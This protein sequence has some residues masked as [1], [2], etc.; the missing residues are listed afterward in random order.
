MKVYQVLV[1]YVASKLNR[2]F[3]YVYN[4]DIPLYSRVIVSFNNRQCVGFIID[5]IETDSLD[6]YQKK[7]GVIIKNIDQV[8]D[9]EPLINEELF[10]LAKKVADYYLCPLISVILAML[11]PSLKPNKSSLHGVKVAFDTYVE[12][13]PGATFDNLTV[14]QAEVFYK[15][16]Q[17]KILKRDLSKTIVEN[18]LKKNKI[19]LVNIE[20]NR[21]KLDS[22]KEY[23][24][25]ELNDEQKIAYEDFISSDDK[26]YLLYGVT[27]SGKTE[28]YL[29]LTRYYLERKQKVLILVPEI[30]LSYLMVE[31][32]TSLFDKVAVLHSS[33]SDGERYDTYRNIKKGEYDVVIGT[34]SA[35]FAPL[36]NL[37]LIIIDEE[38]ADTYKQ[39]DNLPYYNALTVA[40]MRLINGKLLLGSATPSLESKARALKK[41]YHELRLTK[42]VND[43]SLPECEIV[44]MSDYHNIDRNSFLISKRLRELIKD[45][46]EKQEQVILLVNRR[47]FA[48]FVS[49]KSC[50]HI[51][52]CPSCDTALTYHKD[53]NKL[54]CHHCG[55]EEDMILTCPKCHSSKVYKSGFGTE[56]VVDEAKKLFP[57][58]RILRLDSDISKRKNGI[59]SVIDKFSNHEAD[60]LVGTQIVSKGH[61]FPHVNLI[62]VVLADIALSLP[63]YKANERT[64]SLLTQTIGRAGR[65]NAGKAIIQTY[66]PDNFVINLAAK[67]DYDTFFNKELRYRHLLQNPPYTYLTMLI[68]SSEDEDFLVE[69]MDEIK[70]YLLFHLDINQV[71]ILGPS[72]MFINKYLNRYRRKFIL[73]Y[74]DFSLVKD[75]LITLQDIISSQSKLQLTIDVDPEQDY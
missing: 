63:S 69:K 64:F 35:I 58:A 20:R 70:K 11:P 15:L 14:R 30:A 54:V 13:L 75:T 26:V 24:L 6:E 49:C 21:L 9:E 8:I 7:T 18:L 74:K 52:K 53:I 65:R 43:I 55:Y 2:P 1:E 48:P 72:T 16:N 25:H 59:K 67:Q 57:E 71:E 68:L 51:M 31:R 27:G 36:D 19:R 41:R 23:Q 33:L 22:D 66:L 4:G 37:G 73:K 56:R 42:R 40:K 17:G 50:G 46:L 45:N 47:G 28:I 60:I 62:G 44:D 29:N 32:F 38:H 5:I 12:A 10:S 61:D 3:S 39:E 34:R